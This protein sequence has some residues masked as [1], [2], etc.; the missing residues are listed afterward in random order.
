MQLEGYQKVRSKME[1]KLINISKY[2]FRI[3]ENKNLDKLEKL[4]TK[5]NILIDWENKIIGRKKVLNFCRNLFEKNEIKIK[6]IKIYTLKNRYTTS[7]QIEIKLNKK[8][9]LRVV[10]I[11]HFNKNYKIKKI[12]AY[13]G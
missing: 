12:E 6:V 1:K 13:K 10:D 3:F 8:I 7:C 2:Y 9:Y 11:I 4:F 5:D